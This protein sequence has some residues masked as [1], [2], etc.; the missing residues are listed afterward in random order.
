MDL[1]GT[2]AEAETEAR[3]E[4]SLRRALGAGFDALYARGAALDEHEMA[5]L[6]FEQLEAIVAHLDPATEPRSE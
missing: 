3:Y 4:S 1:P 6:A 5:L 2:R